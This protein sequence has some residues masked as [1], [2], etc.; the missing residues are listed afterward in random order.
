MCVCLKLNAFLITTKMII[1]VLEDG[2]YV[3]INLENI[4]MAIHYKSR[5]LEH[6]I[7]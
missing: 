7:N 1:H 3:V 6:A 4:C 5:I 2:I